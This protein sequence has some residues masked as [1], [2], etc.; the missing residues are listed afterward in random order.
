MK[1]LLS[2]YLAPVRNSDGGIPKSDF[3]ALVIITGL[4]SLLGFLLTVLAMTA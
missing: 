1:R 2:R 3:T 4:V